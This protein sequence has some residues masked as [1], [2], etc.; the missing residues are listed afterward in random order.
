MWAPRTEINFYFNF[1][2]GLII[3]TTCS[4]G[5]SKEQNELQNSEMQWI[6]LLLYKLVQGYISCIILNHYIFPRVWS[7]LFILEPSKI[8]TFVFG[9]FLWSQ[10][11][12]RS[13]TCH[14]H[15]AQQSINDVHNF[16]QRHSSETVGVPTHG[17]GSESCR[18]K[19]IKPKWLSPRTQIVFSSSETLP[20]C[21][22]K[23]GET[24]ILIKI[25]SV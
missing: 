9:L 4:G 3:I 21:N 18:S 6:S 17:S 23:P 20:H 8:S 19:P 16:R 14:T 1:K 15:T 7:F 24:A 2:K 22:R 13:I 10:K 25:W 12:L 5:D 11:A